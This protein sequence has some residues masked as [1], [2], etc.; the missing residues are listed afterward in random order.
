M[1]VQ[2]VHINSREIIGGSCLEVQLANCR[3]GIPFLGGE[4]QP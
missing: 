2:C 1:H 3:Q 4:L